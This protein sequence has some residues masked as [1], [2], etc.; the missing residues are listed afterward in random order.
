MRRISIIVLLVLVG[1]FSIKAQELSAMKPALSGN[2]T[3]DSRALFYEAAAQKNVVLPELPQK[4]SPALAGLMSLIVPG[5]GELY[6]GHYYEAAVFFAVDVAAITVAVK[7]NQKGDDKTTEFENVADNRWSVVRYAQWIANRNNQDPGKTPT[8]PD[9][10]IDTN[11]THG[12]PWD[13]V[14]WDSLNYYEQ[15]FS[16]HLEKHGE[17][18]YYELVGK[19]RQ[20]TAGWDEYNGGDIYTTIPAVVTAY[21]NMRGKAN[22]YYNYS[23]KA[24]IVIYLNH[25]LSAVNAVWGAVSYNRNIQ[26]ESSIDRKYL[27]GVTDYAPTLKMKW[28]F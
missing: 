19:Y 27:Q 1:A 17:Q 15:D 28:Y 23:S 13:R 16:H 12:K 6:T 5:A 14:N 8:N 18:Q 7:Y 11:P 10:W 21:E 20:F 9:N 22:D 3:V 25:V 4:K 24:V 26:V 2:L